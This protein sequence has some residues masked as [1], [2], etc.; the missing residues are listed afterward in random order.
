MSGLTERPT[1]N[2]EPIVRAIQA[3]VQA[4]ARSTPL[5]FEANGVPGSA[6]PNRPTREA[7]VHIARE[8]VTNATKHARPNAIEVSLNYTG[9][10]HLTVRDEGNGFDAE[11][12]ANSFGLTSMRAHVRDLGGVLHISSAAE[13]GSV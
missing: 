9:Q 2:S 1:R 4:A 6:R 10:W 7:L 5:T 12:H 3:S 11:D 13:K 8:A